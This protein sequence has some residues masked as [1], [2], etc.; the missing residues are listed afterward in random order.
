MEFCFLK[1]VLLSLCE[2][3]CYNTDY[4]VCLEACDPEC[5]SS[6]V[7]DQEARVVRRC[8]HFELMSVVVVICLEPV[9]A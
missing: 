9:Q 5:L 3:R 1:F 4:I 2:A 7:R 8:P 6:F